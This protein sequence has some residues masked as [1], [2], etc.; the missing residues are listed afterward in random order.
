MD[1]RIKKFKYSNQ[2]KI[3]IGSIYTCI[4]VLKGLT[5]RKRDKRRKVSVS[6]KLIFN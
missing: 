3:K 4:G 2:E 5:E 6:N 1:Q